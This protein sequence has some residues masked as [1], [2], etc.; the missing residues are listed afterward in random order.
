M[1]QELSLRTST[2]CLSTATE[3]GATV[4]HGQEG[5]K[6]KG[7]VGRKGS[8]GG[9]EMLDDG[10]KCFCDSKME[11]AEKVC[12]DVCSGWFH[13][14]CMGMK[15]GAGIMKGK[16]FVMPLLCGLSYAEDKGENCGT[17]KGVRWG[18]E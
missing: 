13:L 12:C 5:G 11:K 8:E 10:I 18:S 14:K 3:E 15:E 6:G 1:A 4:A 16:E 2:E 7:G 17:K 9:R